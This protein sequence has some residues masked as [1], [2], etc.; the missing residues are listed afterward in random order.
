MIGLLWRLGATSVLCLAM[1]TVYTTINEQP[2]ARTTVTMPSWV[3]FC[4]AFAVPY[5]AMLFFTWV[6]PITLEDARRFWACLLAMACAYLLIMPWWI[7]I[8]TTLPRPPMPLGWWAGAYR[9]IVGMD[10]PNNVMPCAHGMGPIVAAWF[11]GRDRPTWRWPLVGLL[12]LGLPS[13]ALIWQ[14]RPIDIVFGGMAAAVGIAAGESLSRG[15]QTQNVGSAGET[16]RSLGA[17]GKAQQVGMSRR[18]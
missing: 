6:A 17:M 9:G 18:R 1:I 16:E 14:H 12:A 2:Y 5:V 10:V 15:R 8:P 13:I 3:P 7:V 11:I 4:P